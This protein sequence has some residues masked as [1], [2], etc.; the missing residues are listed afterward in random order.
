MAEEARK[1][2]I[3]DSLRQVELARIK[4]EAEAERKRLEE[5]KQKALEAARVAAEEKRKA[6]EAARKALEEEERRKDEEARIA[7]E[8]AAAAKKAEEAKRKAEEE[9]IAAELAVKREQEKADSI[10]KVKLAEEAKR[11]EALAESERR[12][13]AVEDYK[14]QQQQSAKA[15][16]TSSE[17][18]EVDISRLQGVEKAKYLNTMAAKYGEGKHTRKI[19]EKNRVI[20]IVV[21]VKEGKATEY[22]WVKTSY[23]GN[24]YFKNGGSI[25]ATQYG[26]GTSS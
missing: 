10:A 11:K 8:V 1:K 22:K 12:K 15:L 23:G 3:E 5:E 19:E 18:K 13:K 21:V 7:A 16:V 17:P 6:E 14:K 24:Y 25:S 20:T 9:R 26:M 4:A 2:A